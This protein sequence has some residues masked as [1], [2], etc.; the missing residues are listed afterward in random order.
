MSG[1]CLSRNDLIASLSSLF[2]KRFPIEFAFHDA[3]TRGSWVGGWVGGSRQGKIS[4][5]SKSAHSPSDCSWLGYVCGDDDDEGEAEIVPHLP[6][7]A[8][9][10]LDV[11]AKELRFLLWG[12]VVFSRALADQ[13]P[14]HLYHP[15]SSPTAHSPLANTP[16]TLHGPAHFGAG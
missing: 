11:F 5:H 3:K 13:E 7:G 1:L 9:N 15:S 12:A 6:A 16:R 4:A 2:L 10:H 14:V 8:S